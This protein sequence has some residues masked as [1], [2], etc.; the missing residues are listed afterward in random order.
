MALE[1]N[2]VVPVDTHVFKI[3]S[4]KYLTHLP[5]EYSKLSVRNF[6]EIQDFWVE[7]FGD[8]AGWTQTTLFTNQLSAFKQKQPAKRART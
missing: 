4:T 1:M 5:K 7:R 2:Q 6:E 3:T 8:Y